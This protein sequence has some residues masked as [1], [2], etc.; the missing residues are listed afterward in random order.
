[1]KIIL[2]TFF[3]FNIS[4]CFSTDILNNNYTNL[5]KRNRSSERQ[6]YEPPFE[7]RKID[8]NA[9]KYFQNIL[10]KINK[11]KKNLLEAFNYLTGKGVTKNSKLAYKMFNNLANN[12]IYNS[13]KV[14]SLYN[15][16]YMQY[17][18]LGCK[19]NYKLAYINLKNLDPKYLT[20]KN[21]ER[22]VFNLAIMEIFGLGCEKNHNSSYKNFCKLNINNFKGKKKNL[23]LYKI[24]YGIFRCWM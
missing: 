18:G 4:N 19:K 21:K 3:L 22:R 24:I 15:I 17:N 2:L 1:M 10:Q 12:S 13:V 6:Y 9:E 16:A 11:D 5:G 14:N 20:F 8:L 7:R 23:I